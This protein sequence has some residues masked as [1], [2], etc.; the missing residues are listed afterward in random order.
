VRV[1]TLMK[2]LDKW[3]DT[4]AGSATN[5]WCLLGF[6]Q[7]T[8]TGENIRKYFDRKELNT[9][10]VKRCHEPDLMKKNDHLTYGAEINYIYGFSKSFAARHRTRLQMYADDWANKKVRT[11]SATNLGYASFKFMQQ[12]GEKFYSEKNSKIANK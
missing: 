5:V 10:F 8:I 1:D 12:I 6:D 3:W 4:V 9:E 11:A 7:K 2:A